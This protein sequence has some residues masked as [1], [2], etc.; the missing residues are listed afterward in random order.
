[1]LIAVELVEPGSKEPD[2]A[3]CAR[4]LEET[5]KRGLLVGK[6]GFYGNVLRLAPPLTLTEEEA[7][8]GL[9]ILADS[10]RAA[11]RKR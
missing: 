11:G 1:L 3:G 6:G 9:G 10:L 2:V 7:D 5:K 4:A 8:E